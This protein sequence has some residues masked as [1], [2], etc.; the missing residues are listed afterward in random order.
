MGDVP[1]VVRRIAEAL[2]EKPDEI[3]ISE[4]DKGKY[5]YVQLEV[6]DEDM[7]RMIGREG[8]VANAI[9]ALLDIAPDDKQWRLEIKD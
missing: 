1:G 7:G 5:R 3:E 8:R 2:C 9:R 4:Y 6:A